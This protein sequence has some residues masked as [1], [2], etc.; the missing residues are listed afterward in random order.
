MYEDTVVSFSHPD[1]I[2]IE[3][4]LTAVLRTGARPL[5]AVRCGSRDRACN[6]A[7]TI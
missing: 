7:P 4:P 2:S 1:S 3:D 5:L 6:V